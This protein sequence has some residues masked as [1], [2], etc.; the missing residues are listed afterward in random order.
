[1]IALAYFCWNR[2]SC[3]GS[4]STSFGLAHAPAHSRREDD[5]LAAPS[6]AFF[7]CILRQLD[8]PAIGTY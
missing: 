7:H 3:P 2:R 1:V 8:D 5:L 6:P 4:L